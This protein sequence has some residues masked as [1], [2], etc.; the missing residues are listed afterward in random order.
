MEELHQG[1]S[2]CTPKHQV[3]PSSIEAVLR[4]HDST[5]LLLPHSGSCLQPVPTATEETCGEHLVAYSC[6]N[7]VLIM[8]LGCAN[9]WVNCYLQCSGVGFVDR[10][11]TSGHN[12]MFFTWND[13]RKKIATFT[14]EL[15]V[16]VLH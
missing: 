4:G 2:F 3:I 16:C 13:A 5:K 10:G 1:L 7:M 6:E 14:V 15:R 11:S 12:V 9:N 8:L